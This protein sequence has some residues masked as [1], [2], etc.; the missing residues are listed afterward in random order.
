MAAADCLCAGCDHCG[1]EHTE[2]LPS[3]TTQEVP[4]QRVH[5]AGPRQSS[6]LPGH[7]GP[8]G[9]NCFL[10]VLEIQEGKHVHSIL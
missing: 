3:F 5:T 9:Q 2:D 1:Y 7:R 8:W 6:P 10:Q 4:C